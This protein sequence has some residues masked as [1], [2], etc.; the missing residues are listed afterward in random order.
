MKVLVIGGGGRE[1]A[2]AWKLRQS[3]LLKELY[4]APGNPGTASIATNLELTAKNIGALA[5]WAV[6]NEIDLTIVGPEAPLAAG[7]VDVFVEHGLRVFG[8][9][10]AAAQLEAS[11]SYAKKVM[12]KAGVP[13]PDAEIFTDFDSARDYVL[14]KGAPIVIKADGLAAG[15]GVIV[16]LTTDEAIAGLKQCLLDEQFGDSGRKVVVE[17]FIDGY[18]ASVMAIVDG[19]SVVPL[20][21]SQ[22][23]KRVFDGDQ[24]PNTGGMGAISPTS[25]LE[26]RRVENLVGEIFLPV[27]RELWAQGIKYVGFLYAGVIVSKKTG[28]IKVL[29]FN[30]RLGDPETQ[31]LLVRLQSDLLHALDAAVL[32]KLSAVELQW[33]KEA[34]CCVVMCSEG[35]PGELNDGKEIS[36]LFDESDGALLFH[37]G[38]AYAPDKS[39][40]VISKGGRVLTISAL[41]SNMK[42]A[43]AKAYG[44]V[45]KINFDGMLFRKD[46]GGGI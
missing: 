33:K 15:K 1:H 10:K 25:V 29:E 12:K 6:E 13:T 3:P 9:T 32:G 17:E 40:K 26:D 21:V 39:G 24:G 8:P 37:A 38:T 36:G 45:K 30:C 22:D 23:Y 28:E 2:I 31:V 42:E 7:L 14:E 4:C 43:V 35:Y 41:G 11:K 34:A 20:V 46:I 27:L 44:G 19:T 18:E 5:L 16:A